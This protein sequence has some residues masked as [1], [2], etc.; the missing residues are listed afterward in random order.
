M[1]LIPSMTSANTALDGTGT[2]TTLV[3]AGASGAV[4]RSLMLKSVGTNPSSL[5]RLFINNGGTNAAAA[6]NQLF[7]EFQLP[8]STAS[9]HFPTPKLTLPMG[10]NLPAGYKLNAT[11]AVAVTGGWT[12]LP[13]WADN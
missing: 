7:D 11:L 4:I 10:I 3:T 5:L 9:D 13:D 1:S 6:N 2:V 12:I 8:A